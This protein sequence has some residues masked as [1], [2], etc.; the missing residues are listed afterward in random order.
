MSYQQIRG[1]LESITTTALVSAG[2]TRVY[3]DN[4]AHT[5]PDAAQAYADITISFATAKLD[6]LGL[7]GGNDYITGTIAVFIFTPANSGSVS[8]ELAALTVFQNWCGEK[9][10]RLRKFDGPR[11]IADAE[12][13]VHQLYSISAAFTGSIGFSFPACPEYSFS[14]A[15]CDCIDTTFYVC[16]DILDPADVSI[17]DYTDPEVFPSG[18]T[19]EYDNAEV[20]N[21]EDVNKTLE[22]LA[23]E[24]S[25]QLV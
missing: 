22:K 16:G 12:N 7:C 8:G 20:L 2:I 3:Y 1:R 11:S 10:V 17:C 18:G 4:I 19:A 14:A 21:L 6:T 15:T 25:C 9:E 23:A 5:Q 24:N 13:S